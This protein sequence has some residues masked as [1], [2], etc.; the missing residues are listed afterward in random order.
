MNISLS[1]AFPPPQYLSMPAFGLD[2]SDETIKFIRLKPRGSSIHIAE[3]GRK[4]IPKGI[5]AGGEI[6]KIDELAKILSE[7]IVQSFGFRYAYLTLPEEK[8]Y[9]NIVEL[10][11]M[12]HDE[13]RTALEAQF[14]EYVPLPPEEAVFDFEILH[15]KTLQGTKRFEV[16]MVSFPR[17]LVESYR[18]VLRKAGIT[19]IAFDAEVQALARSVIPK[20]VK[21]PFLIIDFGKTRTTFIIAHEGN[22]RF[23][24]TVPVAGKDIDR[25]IAEK[26]SL[27]LEEAEQVKKKN[28]NIVDAAHRDIFEAVLPVLSAV[29]GELERYISFWETHAPGMHGRGKYGP[30]KKIFLCGGDSNLTGFPEYLAHNIHI[31]VEHANVW[32]NIVSF[33]DYIPEIPFR[34]SLLYGSAIGAALRSFWI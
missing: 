28:V 4:T 23:T 26:L 7:E 29:R 20:D 8:G 31:P 9:M 1:N 34:E 18:A 27:P 17:A 15:S 12:S 22:V 21:D 16:A 30:I 3:Y 24:S 10:P 32:T 13:M 19:P 14:S 6:K 25:I 5:I 33:E 2:I 11:V